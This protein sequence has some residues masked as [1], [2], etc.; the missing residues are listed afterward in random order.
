METG[1]SVE[2]FLRR[3][4]GFKHEFLGAVAGVMLG[5]NLL[6]GFV[7]AYAIKSLNFQKR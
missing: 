1:E 3:Y 5:F 7:F 2:G 4:F 6:F